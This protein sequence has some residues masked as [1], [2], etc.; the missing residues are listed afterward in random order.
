MVRLLKRC[1]ATAAKYV[2]TINIPTVALVLKKGQTMYFS[3]IWKN[4]FL[5]HL[6]YRKNKVCKKHLQ[7]AI[8]SLL[9]IPFESGRGAFWATYRGHYY[10]AS[11]SE[12]FSMSNL[13]R[14]QMAIWDGWWDL[15]CYF[16]NSIYYL[17]LCS[18]D[19]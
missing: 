17:V 5:G 19:I 3:K 18:V 2:S 13:R 9:V 6:D 7:G 4:Y 15:F 16:S 8:S 14:P 11:L 10:I 12:Y 1:W